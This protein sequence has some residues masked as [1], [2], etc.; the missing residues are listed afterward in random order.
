MQPTVTLGQ[1][2]HGKCLAEAKNDSYT[3]NNLVTQR[4]GMATTTGNEQAI[5]KLSFLELTFLPEE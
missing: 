5:P 1:R 4:L 3:T 2:D